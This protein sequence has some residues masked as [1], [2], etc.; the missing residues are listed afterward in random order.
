[1]ISATVTPNPDTL[2]PVNN[3]TADVSQTA[4]TAPGTTIIPLYLSA[5]PN[6]YTN[7]VTVGGAVP[8]GT[9]TNYIT[10]VDS[11]SVPDYSTNALSI[12]SGMPVIT[13]QPAF[14]QFH[15]GAVGAA[16]GFTGA[17]SGSI[18]LHYQ[19]AKGAIGGNL[20]TNLTNAGQVNGATTTNLVISNLS[21]TNVGTYV[22]IVG[23]SFGSVTSSPAI[24]TALD[25]RAFGD[26]VAGLSPVA[27]YEFNELA[28]PADGGV[29]AYNAI[30]GHNGTYGTNS[31]NGY[32]G[33]VGPQAPVFPGFTTTNLPGSFV[34]LPAWDLNTN[35]VTL[36]ARINP[37]NY[38]GG[39]GI[40]LCNDGKL[41]SGLVNCG[42]AGNGISVNFE[43][44]AGITPWT[45]AE[46]AGFVTLSNWNTIQPANNNDPCAGTTPLVD[47]TGATTGA[48]C[49]WSSSYAH[50]AVS[51]TPGNP[52]LF[53]TWLDATDG[54]GRPSI[55]TVTNLPPSAAGYAVYVYC[56]GGTE[57]GTFSI[58][59][60]GSTAPTYAVTGAGTFA[61]TPGFRSPGQMR[62]AIIFCGRFPMCRDS[63]SPMSWPRARRSTVSKSSRWL[64]VF[65]PMV[66]LWVTIGTVIP[67]LRVGIRAWCRPRTSGH[68]RPWW[69]RR[70]TPR[71]ICSTRMALLRRRSL[72]PT[73][74][75]PL[76]A[77]SW[78]DRVPPPHRLPPLMAASMMW[79]C[80]I[81]A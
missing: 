26:T 15:V 62:M 64:V 72:I 56:A 4:G 1:M 63:L 17:A 35:T 53:A 20:Y 37:S 75:P 10:A 18:T 51:A 2:N 43:G 65:P 5:T 69:C 55:V 38:V 30:G 11:A 76:P 31:L 24:L 50:E 42:S 78:W 9:V 46:S 45:A 70:P 3:V 33:I 27:F 61:P 13:G 40:V 48:T 59:Y 49:I 52:H 8:I 77:T 58:S 25:T 19:W 67:W 6:V 21:V 79:A 23:N 54:T 71:F 44:P 47:S 34:T 68:W 73:P 14:A 22:L 74:W 57:A 12:L 36:T 28:N 60:P 7:S 41:A 39:A 81:T 66:P 29:I 80:S 16:A 32:D